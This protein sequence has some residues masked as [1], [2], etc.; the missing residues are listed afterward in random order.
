MTLHFSRTLKVENPLL[1]A[2]E[3]DETYRNDSKKS[4]FFLNFSLQIDPDPKILALSCHITDQKAKAHPFSKRMFPDDVPGAI[5]FF[6]QYNLFCGIK[7]IANLLE[8][9]GIVFPKE[10]LVRLV[11]GRRPKYSARSQPIIRS[12]GPG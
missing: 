11:L 2:R 5:Q 6:S 7:G 4:R 1:T 8:A 3:V 10:E 12:N 9:P